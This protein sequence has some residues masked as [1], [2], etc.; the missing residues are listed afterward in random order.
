M[1][2]NSSRRPKRR[3]TEIKNLI[4]S[5]FKGKRRTIRNISKIARVDW[6]TT[7]RNLEELKLFGLVE[8]RITTPTTR[9]FRITKNGESYVKRLP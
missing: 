3:A 5:S 7:V 6:I 8:E 1:A 2:N 9:I 4:L